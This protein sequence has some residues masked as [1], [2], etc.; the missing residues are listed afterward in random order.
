M[1]DSRSAPLDRTSHTMRERKG[2]A[3]AVGFAWRAWVASE[4]VRTCPCATHGHV[5]SQQLLEE[6]I[7]N[8][9]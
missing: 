5:F 6:T 4:V 1:I 2:G 8:D 9:W 7:I 3:A